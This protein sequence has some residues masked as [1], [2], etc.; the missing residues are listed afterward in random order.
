MDQQEHRTKHKGHTI[1]VTA[2]PNGRWWTWSYLV[3]GRTYSVGKVPCSTAEAALRQGLAAAKA[4][5][6]EG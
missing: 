4:R 2:T 1:V 5:V 6:E 3:D